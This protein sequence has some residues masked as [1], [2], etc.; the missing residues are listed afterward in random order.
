[1]KIIEISVSDDYKIPKFIE[2]A[3]PRQWERVLTMLDDIGELT[4]NND[5]SQ[6]DELIKQSVALQEQLKALTSSFEDKEKQHNIALDKLKKQ[7]ISQKNTITNDLKQ[8]HETK[9]TDLQAQL[10]AIHSTEL[11]KLQ[12]KIDSLQTELR[13]KEQSTQELIDFSLEN[14]EKQ[15]SSIREALAAQVNKLR[16]ENE[17]LK[18]TIKNNEEALSFSISTAVASSLTSIKQQHEERII[19]LHSQ[20]N[21]QKEAYSQTLHQSLQE[22]KA[23]LSSTY[24]QKTLEYEKTIASLTNSISSLQ[25]E[26]NSSI[27]S[28]ITSLSNK[29]DPLVKMYTGTNEEKGSLGEKSIRDILIND[30]SYK[31]AIINDTSSSRALGDFIFKWRTLSCLF[32]IKNKKTLTLEDMNKFA[33]DIRD[34]ASST[35]HVNCGVFVSI[36]TNNFPSRT[37]ETI[38]LDYIDSIPVVYIHAPPPSTSV[39]SAIILLDK[40]LSIAAASSETSSSINFLQQSIRQHYNFLLSNKKDIEKEITTHKRAIVSL[41]KKLNEIIN[42]ID[43]LDTLSFIHQN[44]Q[45]NHVNNQTNN[46][47]DKSSSS[48]DDDIRSDIIYKFI[49]LTKKL[50]KYPSLEELQSSLSITKN[51]IDSFGGYRQ[52]TLD[53]IETHLY[54][55]ISVEV[56]DAFNSY[57]ADKDITSITRKQL[58]KDRVITQY[59]FQKILTVVKVPNIVETIAE[60]CSA[61]HENYPSADG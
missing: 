6:H 33:R 25:Q 42:M 8:Q 2:T 3:T 19:E 13:K 29:L 23:V 39:T 58:E 36:H 9:I 38:Q 50:K 34:S 55:N 48:S 44:N 49:E 30:P 11:E 57:I 21:S 40:V 18:N 12:T 46:T 17:S 56:V 10:H 22:M 51:T 28:S 60:F 20:I 47:D 24:E 41:T 15:H 35:F 16:E 53:A 1:M 5:N 26:R 31:E 7:L 59:L 37:R 32:E 54:E 61:Y 45:N 14:A 52:I 27:T 43:S 4:K